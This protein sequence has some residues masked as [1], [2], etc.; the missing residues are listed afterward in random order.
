MSAPTP[1]AYEGPIVITRT[2]KGFFTY[3]PDKEDLFI[4]GENLGGAFPGDIVKVEET[5]MHTDPRTGQKRLQGK[6]VKT[7]RRNRTTF[8]LGEDVRAVPRARRVLAAREEGR[9][10]P[11]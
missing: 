1:G 4:P 9:R 3:D 11:D 7:V 2:G 6:V 10:A 5:G 8:G